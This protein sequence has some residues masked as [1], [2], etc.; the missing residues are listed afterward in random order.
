MLLL[1]SAC[2][3]YVIDGLICVCHVL[4]MLRYVSCV[5]GC[6]YEGDVSPSKVTEVRTCFKQAI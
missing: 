4:V 3:A 2:S 1:H 6:P 5:L